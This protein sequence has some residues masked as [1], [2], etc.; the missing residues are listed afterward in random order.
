MKARFFKA[1]KVQ[2]LTSSIHD[3]L[4]TY[5]TGN[6]DFITSDPDNYFE[7]SLE[8]DEVKLASIDCDNYDQKEV[9]NCILMYEAMGEISHYLARDERLWT[10][11]THT[12]LLKYARNRW[13]IPDDDEKAIKHI[14]NHY[15]Y[16]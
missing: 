4:E 9:K 11:L 3:D 7:T 2:E 14:K 10:Y 15:F 16:I 6:F 5:R 8:I 13:P 1:Q 12:L